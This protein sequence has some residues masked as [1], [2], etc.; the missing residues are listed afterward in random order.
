MFDNLEECL[1]EIKETLQE[2]KDDMED[3]TDVLG[4]DDDDLKKTIHPIPE[5]L[6]AVHDRLTLHNIR[7]DTLT[8]KLDTLVDF[9]DKVIG[10]LKEA[11]DEGCASKVAN[12]WMVALILI[13]LVGMFTGG[14]C[15]HNQL[16][17]LHGEVQS[18]G[19][20]P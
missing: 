2:V 14:L 4:F 18:I 17:K 19:Q 15:L 10:T 12:G 16:G 3:V 9:Q 7:F 1:S 8:A 20:R 11:R 6:D 5:R 13:A